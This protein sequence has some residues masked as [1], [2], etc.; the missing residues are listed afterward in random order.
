MQ[1]DFIA[2]HDHVLIE[3]VP[4]T[5]SP[6]GIQLLQPNDEASDLE[7]RTGIVCYVGPGP[8]LEDGSRAQCQAQ[9]GRTV[10]YYVMPSR[11][12]R[13]VVNGKELDIVRDNDIVGW[14]DE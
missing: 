7:V 11:A 12:R 2:C 14:Y 5:V 6:G 13:R 3:H 10:E 4:V 1:R 8:L 9:A